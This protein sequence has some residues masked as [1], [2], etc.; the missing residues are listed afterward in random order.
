MRSPLQRT[1]SA[2]N[3]HE[4]VQSVGQRDQLKEA[5]RVIITRA[6]RS[7]YPLW[8]D[9]TVR[10][11]RSANPHIRITDVEL[12]DALTLAAASAGVS[13]KSV[14]ASKRRPAIR[15]PAVYFATP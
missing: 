3:A 12:R 10:S 13:I 14:R 15:P 7:G 8:E 4:V 1:E 6:A 2:M 5:I 11:L 9:M